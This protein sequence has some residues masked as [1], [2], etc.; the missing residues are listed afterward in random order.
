ML[1]ELK[2]HIDKEQGKTKHEAPRSANYSATQNKNNIGAT[3]LERSVLYTNR[4]GGGRG[5]RFSLYKLHPGS[6]YNS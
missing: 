2:K 3:A 1:K 4:E 5:K 6:R